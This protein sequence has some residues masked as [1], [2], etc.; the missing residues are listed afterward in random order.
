M[1]DHLGCKGGLSKDVPLKSHT[2]YNIHM[3]HVIRKVVSVQ[4]RV[5]CGEWQHLLQY[6]YIQS[7]ATDCACDIT[8]STHAHNNITCSRT[9]LVSTVKLLCKKPPQDHWKGALHQG[10]HYIGVFTTSGCSLHRGVH[11]IGVF[12]TSGCSLH[13]GVHYIGVFTTSGCSLHQGVHYIRVFSTSGFIY[14]RVD[15]CTF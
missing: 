2:G 4:T 12:T 15:T 13:R 5:H 7:V 14:N 1:R 3:A 11:Y 6:T 8:L 9:C 10:V